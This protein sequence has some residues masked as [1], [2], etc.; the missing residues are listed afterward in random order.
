[1][2]TWLQ[3]KGDQIEKTSTQ[4]DGKHYDVDSDDD[5]DDEDLMDMK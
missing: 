1:M 2:I 5:S 3:E 4:K